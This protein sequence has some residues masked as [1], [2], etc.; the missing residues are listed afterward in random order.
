MPAG[1]SALPQWLW[2]V[3]IQKGL[4]GGFLKPCDPHAGLP[5]I[6]IEALRQ[7][8]GFRSC[9]DSPWQSYGHILDFSFCLC[10]ALKESEYVTMGLV[11]PKPGY[12]LE[13]PVC[14]SVGCV[15]GKWPRS[16][17]CSW[18]RPK[19]ARY[20]NDILSFHVLVTNVVCLLLRCGKRM[21][22]ARSQHDTFS[23]VSRLIPL[24]NDFESL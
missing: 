11:R 20:I 23:A 6:I 8:D 18:C 16:S 4:G 12:L 13:S 10:A 24:A 2:G 9:H 15:L 14:C 7:A 21:G 3:H 17:K 22:W 19:F 1:P 5:I